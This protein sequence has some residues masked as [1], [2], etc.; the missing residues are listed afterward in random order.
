MGATFDGISTTTTDGDYVLWSVEDYDS[1]SAVLDTESGGYYYYTLKA[2]FSYYDT[3]AEEAE[4]DKAVNDFL[5]S[6]DVNGKSDFEIIKAV[7][8]FICESCTYDNAASKSP[9][10]HRY[11][12]SSYGV[13]V[14]GNAV[15]QGYASAFY[16]I[17]KELGYGARF[18]TSDPSI[19]NHA[20]NIVRLD[21][22]YYVVDCMWDDDEL[23]GADVS[24]SRGYYF[25]TDYTSSLAYDDF[26][27]Q[28]LLAK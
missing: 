19:G 16:R 2:A 1:P 3:A 27:Q 17:C 13:L 26:K 22:R 28:M 12:F 15:C 14:K 5:N 25:L 10:T 23:E 9:Y 11:A 21:N 18:V 24:F 8:D 7:H 6:F 20:W 4:N